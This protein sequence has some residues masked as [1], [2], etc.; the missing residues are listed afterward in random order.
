VGAVNSSGG[1]SNFGQRPFQ[2]TAPSGFKALVTTNL[3]TPT[4]ED[5]GEYFNTVLYTGTGANLSVTGVGFQPSFV[6]IKSRSAGQSHSLYDAVRGATKQLNSNNT[7]AEGTYAGVSSFDADGFSVGTADN[8]TASATYVAWNWKANGAGVSNTDGTITSTVSANT[9]SG[10][11]I[12]TYTGTGANATWGHGL[13]VA[14]SM[15]IIKGRTN[16]AGWTVYHSAL[17]PTKRL[18]L[19]TTDA[20]ETMGYFQ[21]TSPTSTVFYITSNGATGASGVDYLAYCFAPVAGYSAF[22]SY[23]GNGS[24]D[25]VFVYTGFRPAFL[26]VKNASVAGTGWELHDT[27]RSTYNPSGPLL[28]P[29]VSD[30]EITSTRFDLNSNG[31]KLRSSG[32]SING[33]GNTIIYMA[34]AENPFAY[35]L[36]R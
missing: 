15:V 5:G 26:L 1:S 12:V 13:G 18:S 28:G 17:G 14:P 10:F 24:A 23:T 2:Y 35:S 30:A 32:S 22:G 33:S 11:S 21:D 7:D 27:S 8:N 31:F 36:A 25:G 3:P 6:W 19:N 20:E 16:T 9:D 29:D 4:I 34:F